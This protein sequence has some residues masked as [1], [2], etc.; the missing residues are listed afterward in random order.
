MTPIKS[1][2]KNIN[3]TPVKNHRNI[4]SA[5]RIEKLTRAPIKGNINGH[6]FNFIN[7]NTINGHEGCLRF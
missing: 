4:P 1:D 3:E 2:Y 5:Q 6:K 7:D